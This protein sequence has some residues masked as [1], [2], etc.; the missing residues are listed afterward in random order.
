MGQNTG[1][2]SLWELYEKRGGGGVIKGSKEDTQNGKCHFR[3]KT[4]LA[5]E[6]DKEADSEV[7]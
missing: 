6:E 4:K 5:W 2:W 3:K 7:Q 1:R